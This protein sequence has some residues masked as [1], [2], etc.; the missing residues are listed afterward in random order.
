MAVLF[1][2]LTGNDITKSE[3]MNTIISDRQ[4]ALVTESWK[5]FT[6][7]GDLPDLGIPM[8]LKL[9][10]DH[11]EVKSLFS[12]M[13]AEGISSKHPQFR[14]H[15]NRVFEMIGSAVGSIDDLDTF[16]D[17]LK[18]LGANHYKYG[19]QSAHLPAVGNALLF[20]LEKELREE[21]TNEVR[22]AWL[23]FYSVVSK[24][25]SD[26]LEKKI[27]AMEDDNS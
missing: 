13:R 26:G 1:A 8:F 27:K 5:S 14:R 10:E 16:G 19:T 2:S 25:F 20:A 23:S 4:K 17:V 21:F 7:H 24:C 6:K 12:F 3:Q 11:P 9:F 18:E 15:A 22:N